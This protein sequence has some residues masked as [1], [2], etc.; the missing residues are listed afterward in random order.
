MDRMP[1]FMV[2]GAV[3]A[4]QL[5]MAATALGVARAVAEIAAWPLV[6]AVQRFTAGMAALRISTAPTRLQG[7][8]LAAVA[9]HAK[10]LAL[11]LRGPAATAESKCSFSQRLKPRIGKQQMKG[12]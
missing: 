10:A 9:G 2:A 6:L 12:A 1:C 5:R 3:G 4:A 11:R 8:S 7:H